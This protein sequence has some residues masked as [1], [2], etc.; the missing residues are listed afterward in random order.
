MMD[1][2][3]VMDHGGHA[4]W[5]GRP[6]EVFRHAGGAG[7]RSGLA[8]PQVTRVFLRLR[9]LGRG[10]VDSSGL[11][12]GAGRAGTLLPPEGR[13]ALMLKDITLGQY[14]PGQDG[15]PQAGPPHEASHDGRLYLVALFVA[16]QLV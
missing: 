8:V 13:E 10:P 9:E 15:D 5:T 3:L 6:R 11:H 12:R 4:P 1:R 7:S 16:K 14:L 2:L